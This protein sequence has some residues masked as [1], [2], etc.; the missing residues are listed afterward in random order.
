MAV[1][2][3]GYALRANPTYALPS[4]FFRLAWPGEPLRTDVV[5]IF[6]AGVLV[7]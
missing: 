6:S 1:V 5:L 2:L 4:A 7:E 3:S